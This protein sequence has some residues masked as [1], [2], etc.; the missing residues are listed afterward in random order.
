MRHPDERDNYLDAHRRTKV[1]PMSPDRTLPTPNS[2]LPKRVAR[3]GGVCGAPTCPN[4]PNFTQTV[5]RL[6]FGSWELAVGS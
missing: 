2:Q 3:S 1:L 4:R 5:R 6:S